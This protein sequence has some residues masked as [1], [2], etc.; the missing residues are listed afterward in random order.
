M[1]KFDAKE[2]FDP[3]V[4]AQSA[5]V[6][7]DF[8]ENYHEKSEEQQVF[9]RFVKANQMTD[10]VA[11]LLAQHRA[12]RKVTANILRLAPGSRRDGDERRQLIAAMRSFIGMYRPHAAREDTVL[13]PKLRDIVSGHEFDA[14]GEEMEEREHQHFGEDGFE[15]AVA[16]VAELEKK[17]Q[18]LENSGARSYSDEARIAMQRLTDE[19]KKLRELLSLAGFSETWVE[20]HLKSSGG[21]A[22]SPQSGVAQDISHFGFE[23]A[24]V[25]LV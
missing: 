24:A 10:L 14:I 11:T 15:K 23:A 17:V 8:I 12:G 25:P 4:I 3:A 21:S 2:D 22:G 16:Q 9:P 1:R 13:F 19:N 7:H 18:E 5:Q 20:A 6:I